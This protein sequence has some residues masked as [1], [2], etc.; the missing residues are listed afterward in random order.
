MLKQVILLIFLF[1]SFRLIKTTYFKQFQNQ[2]DYAYE[3]TKHMYVCKNIY[4]SQGKEGKETQYSLTFGLFRTCSQMCMR[5]QRLR[6]TSEWLFL[7]H[8][9]TCP[10]L[11]IQWMYDRAFPC[12]YEESEI[13]MK[14]D[15]I[16]TY[17]A[18]D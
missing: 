4:A 15:K 10:R 2:N 14:F 13:R 18:C 6:F 5:R 7:H 1:K 12:Y 8:T 16:I 11:L 3:L 9:C 17:L